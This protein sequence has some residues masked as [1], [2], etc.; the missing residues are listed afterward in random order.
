M[1]RIIL[2][3]GGQSSG[4]SLYA[5]RRALELS[6]EPVYVATALA[7]GMEER[8]KRHRARRGPEWTTIEEPVKL[9]RLDLAGRV[10]L[11]D[12]VTLW[13]TNLLFSTGNPPDFEVARATAG[14]ELEQFTAREA[15]YI[16]VTNEVGLG[17]VADNALARSF[18][19]LQGTVNQL[20]AE[21]ADE[22][23]MVVSG[24]QVKIK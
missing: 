21:L 23:V 7:E 2:I 6:P 8:V 13:L 24:I 15:V 3:T 16:F 9:G 20:I 11:I 19:D 10:V 5:E 14:R 4:K 12:C 17:G 18:A 22:V 1:R